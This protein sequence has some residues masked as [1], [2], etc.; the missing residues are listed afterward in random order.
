MAST[1]LPGERRLERAG[2][3]AYVVK[4]V[5]HLDL[6]NAM[7]RALGGTEVSHGLRASEAEVPQPL[8]PFHALVAEDNLVNQEVVQG[9]VE[10][11]GGRVTVVEN[12]RRALDAFADGGFDVV[13]MD[14]QMPV[15]DGY[16]ASRAIRE[17]EA[18]SGQ[19]GRVPII[20]LTAHALGDDREKCLAAGMDDYL[21]KPTVLRDLARAL[22][23]H[24]PEKAIAEPPVEV[25]PTVAPAADLDREAIEKIRALGGNTSSAFL[26]KVLNTYLQTT[27][28]L[29]ERMRSA[30]VAGEALALADAAH[31]LK[32][33]SASLGAERLATLCRSLE[34]AG[35]EERLDRAPALFSRLEAEFAQIKT[36]LA[37]EYLAKSA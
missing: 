4:P 5:R 17:H 2:V 18:G 3:T 21:A 23:D 28:A 13:L 31:T 19:G 14:C 11:L 27:P 29:V 36:A 1:S 9:M 20:A 16:G 26:E 33:S 24:L 6:Y 30:L 35:R 37:E 15:L 25:S 8:A 22:R 34:K 7:A 32:S 12:G 10:A